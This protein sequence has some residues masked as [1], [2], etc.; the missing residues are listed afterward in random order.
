MSE[1]AKLLMCKAADI[2]ERTLAIY[3]ATVTRAKEARESDLRRVAALEVS[4]KEV[5]DHEDL[6]TL[7]R[8]ERDDRSEYQVTYIQCN[9]CGLEVE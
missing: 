7:T 2:Q 6:V 3:E 9:T 4:A 1:A 5:C 8:T